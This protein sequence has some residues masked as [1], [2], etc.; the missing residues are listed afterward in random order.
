MGLHL[1]DMVCELCGQ[2]EASTGIKGGTGYLRARYNAVLVSMCPRECSNEATP[3]DAPDFA[4]LPDFHL[5]LCRRKRETGGN[6]AAGWG[7]IDLTLGKD[8][9]VVAGSATN[10][11]DVD[12]VG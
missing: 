9:D 12:I 6:P 8:A 3:G 7:T 1:G 2:L 10:I 11:S 4:R 5:A